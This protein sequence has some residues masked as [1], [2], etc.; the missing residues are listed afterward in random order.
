MNSQSDKDEKSIPHMNT[1]VTD[2]IGCVNKAGGNFEQL[3]LSSVE[4]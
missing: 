2:M 3:T 1:D 4:Q